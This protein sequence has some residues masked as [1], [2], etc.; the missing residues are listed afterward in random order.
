MNSNTI[1]QDD[2]VMPSKMKLNQSLRLRRIG[3]RFV[4]VRIAE[5]E[6]NMTDVISLNE[7]AAALWEKFS[8]REFT[9][10]EMVEWLC[11]EY[12]VEPSVAASDVHNLL[13]RWKEYGMLS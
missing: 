8:G 9:E 10:A 12:E 1:Q 2:G 6:A 7:T 5:G 4:I 13:A 3:S 11:G